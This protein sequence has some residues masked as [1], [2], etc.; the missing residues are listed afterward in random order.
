MLKRTPLLFVLVALLLLGGVM[1]WAHQPVVLAEPANYDCAAQS[2]IPVAE[3]EALVAIYE[4]NP[5]ADLSGWLADGSSPCNWWGVFCNG[6][7]V[8]ELELSS[9]NLTTVPAEIGQLSNLRELDLWGN[10]LTAVPAEIGQLNNLERLYM[11]NNQLTTVP[12]EIGQLSNLTLLDL[13]FNQLTAVPTEIGQLSSLTL[14]DLGSNQLTAVPTAVGQLSNLLELWLNYNQLT[15]LPTEIG[16]LSNLRGLRLDYNQLTALPTEIGQLSNLRVLSLGGNQF[17]AVP[18]EIWQLSDLTSLRLGFNQLTAVSTEIGQLS[19]LRGLNLQSNQL[20]DLPAELWQLSNLQ[21]LLLNDNQLTA[22]STEIGQLS[23]LQWLRL[24]YN[25]LTAVPAAMGQL[26][27]LQTLWLNNNPLSGPIPTSLVPLNNLSSFTFYNSNWCIPTSP[28]TV[29][30]W[31]NGISRVIG[32]GRLC[33]QPAGAISGQVTLTNTLPITQTSITLYRQTFWW[34]R[35]EF[36]AT[37]QPNEQGAY[38]FGDLG[39]GINYFVHFVPPGNSL[40]PQYYNARGTLSS[41]IPVIVT[42][43]MTTTNTNATFEPPMPPLATITTPNGSVTTNPI[44]GTVIVGQVNGQTADITVTRTVLCADESV[45][46]AVVLTL[47]DQSYPMSSTGNPNEYEATIP[48]NDVANGDLTVVATCDGNDESTILGTVTLF[49]PSGI[50]T[51]AQTGDPVVGATVILH[52][53]P[54]WQPKT[55]PKDERPNTCQSH[56]SKGEDEPW[57]QPAPTELGVRVNTDVTTVSPLV[58]QQTTNNIGYYGWDV[59]LGCWYV[60]VQAEGY[61]PLTSPVVGVPPEV[62]DLDLGLLPLAWQPEYGVSLSAMST[63]LT[64]TVDTAVTYTLTLTNT[65]D[66]TD[67]YTLTPTGASWPTQLPLTVTV[68]TEQATQF[69]V[70][71]TIPATTTLGQQDVVMITAISQ[72]DETAT[73]TVMLTTTAVVIPPQTDTRIYLPLITR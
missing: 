2:A 61:E 4:A 29:Q 39:Q 36:V 44:D 18:T 31:L 41:A 5:D 47:G 73:D 22:V 71:V 19:N 57:N 69:E 34:D 33:D 50:I 60:T 23:N 66:I 24:D 55:S 56:E 45:P 17:T 46:T 9:R 70:M 6:D 1:G 51:D 21:E 52:Q 40:A 63:E 65:G 26:S 48:A 37:T 49:D 43:G 20:T 28:D 64:G 59:P 38:S 72:G 30:L 7:V 58:S 42:L 16:Q 13:G 15:A 67:T 14:L 10:E 35:D 62:T 3:C 11:D 68:G 12:T 54:N 53:V 8:T 27:N 32:T 25:Q